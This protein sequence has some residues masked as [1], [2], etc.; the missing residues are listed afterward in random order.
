MIEILL[1]TAIRTSVLPSPRACAHAA[2]LQRL[3]PL[4]SGLT[5][6]P[7]GTRTP[8]EIRRDASAMLRHDER[9][10]MRIRVPP[11]FG[12]G[13][14]GAEAV[15]DL[16]LDRP[17]HLRVRGRQ[18]RLSGALAFLALLAALLRNKVAERPGR[19]AAA[20]VPPRRRRRPPSPGQA[21]TS[22]R[23]AGR[24]A[25]LCLLPSSVSFSSGLLAR[26]CQGPER[27]G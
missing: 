1:Q 10:A 19:Q 6:P 2:Q 8:S 3:V 4:T 22:A 12:R 16:P 11:A 21:D 5:L 20:F 9:E 13:H 18:G 7:L 14:A 26:R 15:L 25:L 24:A 23:R 17:F 27:R